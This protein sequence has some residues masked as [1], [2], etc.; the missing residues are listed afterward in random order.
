MS[1]LERRM[2]RIDMVVL[3]FS[4]ALMVVSDLLCGK[5]E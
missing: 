2:R 1:P 4:K 3:E 5:M